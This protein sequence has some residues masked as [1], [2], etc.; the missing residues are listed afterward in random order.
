MPLVFVHGV[1]N[2][3][4]RE[5]VEETSARRS[6][7]ARYVTASW[8]RPDGGRPEIYQPYWGG[9]GASLAWGGASIPHR[10]HA[11][12]EFGTSPD[13][14]LA[15][16]VAGVVPEG[17]PPCERLL[18]TARHSMADAIDLLLAAALLSSPRQADALAAS[19]YAALSSVRADPRPAWLDDVADD[20][21]FAVRLCDCATVR[22]ARRRC[23]TGL[24]SGGVRRRCT[25]RSDGGGVTGAWQ[26]GRRSRCA[27]RRRPAVVAAAARRRVPVPS[28][29]RHAVKPTS[30]HRRRRA[31]CRPSGPCDTAICR[32]SSGT[33]SHPG[34][35]QNVGDL[36]QAVHP[37]DRQVQRHA[38]QSV[39]NHPV[40]EAP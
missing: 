1:A 34:I 12:E 24:V 36:E 38:Y 29:G 22:H 15:Q 37:L 10:D 17:A 27:G 21:A 3:I 31:E 6:L 7:F 20:E 40:R 23:R 32:F 14:P 33:V 13:D 39:G 25:C 35:W 11:A 18:T 30:R 28:H 8:A 16:V 19:S 4:D 5:Q 2:R 26:R 9:S